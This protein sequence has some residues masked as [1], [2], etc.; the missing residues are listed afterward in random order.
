MFYLHV[1]LCT[2]CVPGDLGDQK[3]TSGPLGTGVTEN[4][5]AAMWTL[6][7]EHEFSVRADSALN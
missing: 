7:T 2:T 5:E 3:R 6:G 1:C 4:C